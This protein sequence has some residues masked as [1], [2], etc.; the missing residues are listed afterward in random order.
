MNYTNRPVLCN[1][2]SNAPCV[3]ICPVTPKAIFK[4]EDG[5]TL[6]NNERCIGCR[7]CQ[8]ACPYS[9]YDVEEEKAQYSVISFNDFEKETPASYRD[10]TETIAAGTSSGYEMARMSGST[11]PHRTRYKHRDYRDVRL[12]G[13]VG[14][15]IF[16]AHRVH[17][18]QL[19][20]CVEACPARAR[21]FS[22]LEDPSSEVSKLLKRYKV[23]VL[24]P[25]AGTKP[26][27]YYIRSFKAARAG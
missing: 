23:T 27:V 7:L 10:R 24:K 5:I 25:A 22:D 2:C 13:V 15:C 12:A 3:A 8:E 9:A 21:I 20:Y 19:P 17:Y 6:T 18:G 16:C 1:H 26:N 14:K 4:S 11:P